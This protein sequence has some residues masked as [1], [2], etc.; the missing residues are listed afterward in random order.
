VLQRV[1]LGNL[2]EVPNCRE[3]GNTFLLPPARQTGVLGGVIIGILPG[4]FA[5]EQ[6]KN[7]LIQG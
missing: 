2:P 7:Q 3:V 4:I 5:V 6:L 1:L